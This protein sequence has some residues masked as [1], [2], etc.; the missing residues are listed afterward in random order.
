MRIHLS[1]KHALKE[2]TSRPPFLLPLLHVNRVGLRRCVFVLS[3][4]LYG[5]VRLARDQARSREVEGT[6]EDTRLA[7]QRARLHD[8]SL[9]LEAVARLPVAEAQHAVVAASEQNALLVHVH[10]VEDVVVPADVHHELR[11]L[12]TPSLRHYRRTLPLL[13]VVRRRRRKHILPTHGH[14]A[15][16]LLRMEQRGSNALLVVRQNRGGFTRQQV[17]RSHRGVRAARHHL[18]LSRL[19]RHA[20]DSAAVP[21]QHHRFRLRSDVPHATD[22]VSASRE[23]E[24][25]SGVRGDA[26]HAAE[27]PVVRAD[28][29]VALQVPALHRLVF[30]AREQVGGARRDRHAANR[31]GVAR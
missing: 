27:M 12:V 25:Q 29:L 13:D 21:A 18:R 4:D 8:R 2:T 17:P 14:T 22:A 9:L 5:L 1:R 28:H 7:L 19:R 3:P 15:P 10:G 24:V 16:L 6:R 23:N 11:L 20:V 26:V 30:T 31:V